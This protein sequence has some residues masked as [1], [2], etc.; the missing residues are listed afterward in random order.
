METFYVLYCAEDDSHALVEEQALLFDEE[1]LSIG[2]EVKFFY[3]G[4]KHPLK[5]VIRGK[6]Q[7]YK[8][9]VSLQ[10][11]LN[12]ISKPKRQRSFSPSRPRQAA[13]KCMEDMNI[14]TIPLKSG[15]PKQVDSLDEQVPLESENRSSSSKRGNG[16]Y[17]DSSESD[18]CSN[19]AT[20]NKGKL[21]VPSD[22]NDSLSSD[23]PPLS[24][25]EEAILAKLQSKKA[26]RELQ[27]LRYLSSHSD[28]SSLAQKS[29]KGRSEDKEMTGSEIFVEEEMSESKDKESKDKESKDKES[30]EKKESKQKKDSDKEKGKSSE[31]RK[32]DDSSS[33]DEAPKM[34][35]PAKKRFKKAKH[36]A[37][38][39]HLA[40]ERE[41]FKWKDSD[42]KVEKLHSSYDVFV[43]SKELKRLKSR[44]VTGT[45][46]ARGA[47][48]LVFTEEA[49]CACS[50]S[51]KPA[52]GK[53]GVRETRTK[54]NSDGV[55]AILDFVKARLAKNKLHC[56]E[57]TLKQAMAN[58][59][60]E[61]RAK[62]P[63][64]SQEDI[65]VQV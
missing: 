61:E 60:C 54:L 12:K 48:R 33:E 32:S 29:D 2:D 5:G 26:A 10:D 1:E 7:N 53:D 56:S 37:P 24:P 35:A 40:F 16:I 41:H 23:E 55:D 13:L 14:K 39:H 22:N 17:T 34:K 57:A 52:P 64:H 3:P 9:M 6:S 47:V 49:I 36:A 19:S 38:L 63:I 45:A 59:L 42:P 27:T 46:L 50:V 21:D 65:E 18:D 58:L 43:K 30:Q 11:K 51:G 44:A 31:K 4:H 28:K 15:K 25:E 8:E 62:V 20:N